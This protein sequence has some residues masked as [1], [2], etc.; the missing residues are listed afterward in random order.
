VSMR[1]ICALM[2]SSLG[3]ISV[4]LQAQ[5]LA[6][7]GGAEV[8]VW[9]VLA[10]LLVS[11]A[12]AAVLAVVLRGRTMGR[13]TKPKWLSVLARPGRIELVE[14][15]RIASQTELSLVRCDG[16]EYV[17]LSGQGKVEVLERRALPSADQAQET[18][19]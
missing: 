8:S 4:P 3:L 13:S 5:Q 17:I 12:A 18:D 19:Q 7:G 2:A 14:T 6:G 9:R 15:R 10:A 1:A 16:T 11:V